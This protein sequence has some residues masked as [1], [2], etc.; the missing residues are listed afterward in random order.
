MPLNDALH[1]RQADAGA[2]VFRAPMQ[3]LKGSEQLVSRRLVEAHAIVAYEEYQRTLVRRQASELDARPGLFGGKLPRIA[4]Q[5]LQYDAEP[6]RIPM[7]DE[8]IRDDKFCLPCRLTS[9][10]I[11][12]HR[13]GQGTHIH[14][15]SYQLT[16]SHV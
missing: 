11:G 2:W 8:T 6:P 1:R 15:L 4:E 9:L 16:S 14:R 13:P 7:G 5:I 12:G 10:Q 3:A